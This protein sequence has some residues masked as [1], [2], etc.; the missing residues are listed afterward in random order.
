MAWPLARLL[1]KFTQRHRS[2]VTK[3]RFKVR[4]L[5]HK[6]MCDQPRAQIRGSNVR[7]IRIEA[8]NISC[9]CGEDIADTGCV[10]KVLLIFPRPFLI[11]GSIEPADGRKYKELD[12]LMMPPPPIVRSE[13]RLYNIIIHGNAGEVTETT[14]SSMNRNIV[15][16]H[17]MDYRDI[18]TKGKWSKV[19]SKESEGLVD[20]EADG[21][22]DT[23]TLRGEKPKPQSRFRRVLYRLVWLAH[24]ALFFAN[25]TWL[26]TWGKWVHPADKFSKSTALAMNQAMSVR[27]LMPRSQQVQYRVPASSTSGETSTCPSAWT[28]H[29]YSRG[30]MCQIRHGKT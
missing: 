15:I 11:R 3:G 26:L 4:S 18:F 5:R 17:T 22:S 19:P 1:V 6:A 8:K 16:Y 20:D 10:L 30:T 23:S 27:G 29:S 9:C 12:L 28:I 25:I 7:C 24:A 2:G 21:Y 13:A 14:S